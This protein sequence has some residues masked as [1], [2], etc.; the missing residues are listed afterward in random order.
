MVGKKGKGTYYQY[1]NH[2]WKEMDGHLLLREKIRSEVKDR[3]FQHIHEIFT[4]TSPTLTAEQCEEIIQDCTQDQNK[5]IKVINSLSSTNFKNQVMDEAKEHFYDKDQTFLNNL[6]SNPNLLGFENGV[7]DLI[8]G[9]FRKGIPEDNISMTTRIEY[10]EYDKYDELVVQVKE[11]LEKVLPV[12]K[13]RDYVLTLLGSFLNGENK[14]ER[15]HIWTGTGGN[16]KSKLIE[17]FEMCIGDYSCKLPISLLTTKRKGSNEA[18]PELARTKG[19][20][21]AILQEPDEH[22]RINV[23]LM[24][25]MTGGDTII[26]RNLYEA[27]IEFKPQIKMILICNHLPELPYDDEATWRRV[28]AVEF[29]SKFVDE[30]DWDSNDPNQF[31]KDENLSQNFKH[32]K[33]PFIWILLQYYKKYIKNG[34]K[35]PP[36]VMECTRQYKDQND[37]FA[38]FFQN[39]LIH[40]ELKE[41]IL[42]IRQ[43]YNHYKDIAIHNSEKPK[44]KKFLKKYFEKQIGP[45]QGS[46]VN[47]GWRGWDIKRTDDLD[48]D[49]T[50]SSTEEILNTELIT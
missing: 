13:V 17:L 18:Q 25:E 21:S 48:D 19:K 37:H 26:A 15:F 12:N 41:E 40:N 11:F 20:R 24:K 23:G 42:T 39:H 34:I 50:I 3:Y 27:P 1:H 28:R 31:V 29:K 10:R 4:K 32:W 14:D 6:D 36:E 47:A 16:G 49:V 2:R 5:L 22:T 30:A 8:N 38:D 44:D 33:E 35:E 45:I 9:K 43:I 46:G 7:Y